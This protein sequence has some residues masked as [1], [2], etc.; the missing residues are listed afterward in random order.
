MANSDGTIASA[1]GE[2]MADRTSVPYFDTRRMLGPAAAAPKINRV[3]HHKFLPLP[4]LTGLV[5]SEVGSSAS[6]VLFSVV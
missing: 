6:S 1:H 3:P 2:I 5:L 4:A